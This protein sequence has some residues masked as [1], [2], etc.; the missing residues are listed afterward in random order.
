MVDLCLKNCKIVP[1]NIECSIGVDN[2]II[3]FIKKIPTKSEKTIDVKGNIVLPGLIDAHVHLRDPGLT[4]KEDFQTGTMAA[5]C[6]GFTT[7]LDMPNTVPPTTTSK[8]FSRKL[9]IAGKKSLVDFGL[10]AGADDLSE[11]KKLSK[12]KPSSFKIYMDQVNDGFLKDAFAEISMLEKNQLISLHAEDKEIVKKCTKK[13]KDEKLTDPE[14]YQ[15]ARPPIA[16][17]VA[18]SKAISMAM[19]L[20]I[21]IH[22]CHVSTKES[23]NIINNAKKDGCRVTSE[24]TPHHLFLSSDYLKKMGNFAK[25]N[26]PLRDKEHELGINDLA[27]IDIIGTDHAP[28]TIPEKEQNVW[29]A[30]PGIPNL[31]TTLPLLLTQVNQNTISFDDIKRLLCENP[32]KIFSLNQKGFIKEGMD[33]DFVVIDMKKE[34]VINPENFRSKAKYSPFEGWNVKGMPIMTMVRGNVVMKDGE[35]FENKGKFVYH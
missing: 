23:L 9:E 12:F 8:A 31:E 13:L 15:K 16:E 14:I 22:I 3:V 20:G 28:H 7:V 2:G 26:P 18:I 6:G 10:H 35:V 34:S 32:S 27:N 21:Q 30:P 1:R 29:D 4:Y 17:T 5:A 33:A 11:I 19:N 24:V 25:T